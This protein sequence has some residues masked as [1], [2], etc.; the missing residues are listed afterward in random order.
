MN[1]INFFTWYSAFGVLTLFQNKFI[2]WNFKDLAL[3][4]D[5]QYQ[6]NEA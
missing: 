5:H 3:L 2:I 1:I 6:D 4:S